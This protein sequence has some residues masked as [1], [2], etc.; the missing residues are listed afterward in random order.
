[1]E[2]KK[3][4]VLLLFDESNLVIF[5]IH[6][7]ELIYK[8]DTWDIEFIGATLTIRQESK[9]IFLEIEFCP[10]NRVNIIRG[11][12][13]C[14]GVEIIIKKTQ[15]LIINTMTGLSN[16]L[17][18]GVIGIQ[19]GRNERGFPSVLGYPNTNRYNTE[20]KTTSIK[21]QSKHKEK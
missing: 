5:K 4:V 9:N 10:P 12:L 21:K 16:C 20:R 1:V 14:N 17:I 18:R 3:T 7:N 8:T 19:I 6:D 11:R 13:L 2:N 15:V